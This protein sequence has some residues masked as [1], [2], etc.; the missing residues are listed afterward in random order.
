MESLGVQCLD[1]GAFLRFGLN[2]QKGRA[3]KQ[4]VSCAVSEPKIF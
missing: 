3:E 1:A 2:F 4:F